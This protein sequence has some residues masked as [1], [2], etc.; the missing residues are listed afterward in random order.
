[1]AAAGYRTVSFQQTPQDFNPLGDLPLNVTSFY[2]KWHLHR[3]PAFPVVSFLSLQ[4]DMFG[5]TLLLS[6]RYFT[7]EPRV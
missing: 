7:A 6:V 2:N 4:I 1:M 5:L 3:I